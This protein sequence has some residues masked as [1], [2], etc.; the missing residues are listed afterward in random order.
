VRIVKT[1]A[2]EGRGI[3]DL[4]ANIR[5]SDAGRAGNRARVEAWSQRLAEMWHERLLARFPAPDLSQAAAEVAAHRRD[6]YSVIKEWSE[7]FGF[8]C[9]PEGAGEIR[10]AS[11]RSNDAELDRNIEPVCGDE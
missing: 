10:E 1:V 8:D 5:A 3:D 4:L 6:P 7:L 2:T 9:F 11:Q